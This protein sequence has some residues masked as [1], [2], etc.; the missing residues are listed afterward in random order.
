MRIKK[1]QYCKPSAKGD[2]CTFESDRTIQC[3]DCSIGDQLQAK[4]V[5]RTK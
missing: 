2:L 4:E 1:C 5:K 3:E